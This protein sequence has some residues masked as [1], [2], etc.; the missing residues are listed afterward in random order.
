MM[1][2][3]YLLYL[4]LG[5]LLCVY[6]SFE[7]FDPNVIVPYNAIQVKNTEESST[8]QKDLEKVH[9]IFP[10]ESDSKYKGVYD[11]SVYPFYNKLTAGSQIMN[12]IIEIIQQKLDTH[13][14]F[15]NSRVQSMRDLYNIQW[16]ND[17][18]NNDVTHFVFN[19]DIKIIPQVLLLKLRV[20]IVISNFDENEQRL[21]N[22][23]IEVISIE[24]ND[25]TN[26][27]DNS[28]DVQPYPNESISMYNAYRTTNTLHLL[29]PFVTNGNV[30]E[31][32]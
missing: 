29:D 14:D 23:D 10:I 15:K 28:L 16:K 22:N 19:M 7:A 20:H 31:M 4:I 17:D 2:Q 3:V 13:P 9:R 6:F 8:F 12:R 1:N 21:S 25:K 18:D 30:V 11:Y 27:N 32:K 26:E 24:T 5:V